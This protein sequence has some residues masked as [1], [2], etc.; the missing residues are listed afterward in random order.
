D[1]RGGR[2]CL[3][4]YRKWRSD[5]IRSSLDNGIFLAL[6]LAAEPCHHLLTLYIEGHA[7]RLQ[8]EAR[9]P[10]AAA[11]GMRG[12]SRERQGRPWRQR[13]DGVVS[14]VVSGV[15]LRGMRGGSKERQGRPWRRQRSDGAVS[16]VVSGVGFRGMQGGSRERQGRPWRQ[17][18]AGAVSG[19]VLRG[20]VR[21]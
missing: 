4:W 10:V 16:G 5:G 3:T 14:G 21:W 7:G 2:G 6:A 12:G 19:V 1:M 8:G 11:Q 15:G 20:V 9:T 18:S 13:S 17:R